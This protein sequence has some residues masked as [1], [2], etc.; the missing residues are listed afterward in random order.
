MAR[1][2]KPTPAPA[3]TPAS[4]PSETTTAAPVPEPAVQADAGAPE[5][6]PATVASRI[7]HD[8]EAYLPDDLILVTEAE[9][10]VLFKAGALV[11]SDWDDCAEDDSSPTG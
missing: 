8:G 4:Q 1:S 7:D 3:S 10:A 2:A 5:R 6:R 11:E 9:F